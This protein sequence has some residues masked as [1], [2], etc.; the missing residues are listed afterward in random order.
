MI[1]E[2]TTYKH[3][4]AN[5]KQGKNC[6][7]MPPQQSPTFLDTALKIAPLVGSAVG[8]LAFIGGII[9]FF[10]VRFY[11][12]RLEP[13]LSNEVV[14]INGAKFLKATCELKNAGNR[15]ATI[16]AQGTSLR[17][18]AGSV[19]ASGEAS[20]ENLETLDV[21]SENAIESGES[22]TDQHLIK[23]PQQGVDVLKVKL[24]VYAGKRDWLVKRLVNL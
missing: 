3:L 11:A 14:T 7:I 22:I 8:F 1:D 16:K 15:R 9:R 19:G 5:I 4:T 23:I 21:F 24:D 12:L 6:L 2:L 10:F 20:W 18:F 17:V 13:S